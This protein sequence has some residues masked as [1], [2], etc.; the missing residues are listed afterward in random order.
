V[1]GRCRRP[2]HDPPVPVELIKLALDQEEEVTQ[3]IERLFKA[4]RDDG[5]F[6]GEQFMLW[7]LKEQVEE[8]AAMTTLLIITERAGNDFFKLEEFLAREGL[9]SGER[10]DS[11]A[12]ATAGGVL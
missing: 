8:V 10:T 9:A 11:S 12:P 2:P 7:F 4:A 5:D 3:R 1:A 6:L